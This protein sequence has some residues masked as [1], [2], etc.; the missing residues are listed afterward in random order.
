MI[1]ELAKAIHQKYNKDQVLKRTLSGGMFFQQAPK[2]IES[3][4][5][6]FF[7]M[8][9]TREEIMGGADDGIEQAEI[10]FI[11]LSKGAGATVMAVQI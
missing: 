3:P 11:L 6:I 4:Y 10:Q 5:A 7:Y 2:D 8:G 1:E 9:G